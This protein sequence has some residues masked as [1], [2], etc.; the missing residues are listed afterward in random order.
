VTSPKGPGTSLLRPEDQPAEHDRD[1][2][3]VADQQVPP[4]P[5]AVDNA[6]RSATV[7]SA[8]V[9]VAQVVRQRDFLQF[10]SRQPDAGVAVSRSLSSELRWAPRRR[11]DFS[12]L[13]VAARLARVLTE[14]GYLYG[15]QTPNGIEFQ[16]SL[17]QPELAAM[18]GASESSVHKALRQLRHDGA[19]ATG[20]RPVVITDLAALDAI[21]SPR[22]GLYRTATG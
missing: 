16:Y 11:V 21:A 10:M 17:T 1:E 5:Q 2:H 9:T 7:I 19:V 14:L 4:G 22:S 15:R 3:D 6:P 12:G 8:G 18:V 20:Y 13:P